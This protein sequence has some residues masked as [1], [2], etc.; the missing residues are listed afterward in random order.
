MK[1]EIA[2]RQ[3]PKGLATLI[4]DLGEGENGFGGT[5]VPKGILTL[6]DYLEYCHIT[7]FLLDVS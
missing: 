3:P 1:L 2:S 5:A 4:T 6:E 7:A